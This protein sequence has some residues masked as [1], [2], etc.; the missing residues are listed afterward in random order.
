MPLDPKDMVGNAPAEDAAPAGTLPPAVP[1]LDDRQAAAMPPGTAALMA[2][3]IDDMIAQRLAALGISAADRLQGAIDT[4]P[5]PEVREALTQ[6]LEADGRIPVTVRLQPFHYQ[7]LAAR[8]AAFGE[9]PER[10]LETILRE[11]RRDDRFRP[12]VNRDPVEKGEA[13]RAV[14]R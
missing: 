1:T 8:A 7:Y 13:A 12:G 5:S 10:M 9:T 2:A 3:T 11:F 4:I 14:P 6:Q